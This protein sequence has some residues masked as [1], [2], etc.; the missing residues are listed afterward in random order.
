MSAITV[1]PTARTAIGDDH[2]VQSTTVVVVG[3][4]PAGLA[5]SRH[6]TA[7]G[8]DHVVLERGRIA[9]RWRSERWD[10]LRLLTPNWLARLPEW[11]YEGDDPDGFMT[12]PEIIGHLAAYAASFA[13][14]VVEQAEVLAAR[15]CAGGFEVDTP[16]CTY[17]SAALIVASGAV[18]T[19]PAWR[20]GLSPSVAQLHSSRYRNPEQIAPGGVL[21]VGASASGLQLAHELNRAGRNVVLS[22]GT[23]IRL[24]RTYRGRDTHWWLDL[25]G[26][27]DTTIAEVAD[28]TAARRGPSLQ[29]AGTPDRRSLD[30]NRL[31]ADGVRLTG[32]AVGARGWTVGFADDLAV[33]CA[34]ADRRLH[35]LLALFDHVAVAAGLT[36]EIAPPSRPEPTRIAPAVA[37]LDLDM[38]GVSTVLWATG[39]RR[40]YPWLHVPVTD[41]AG[42]I[43]HDGGISAWPGLYT[44]GLPFMRRRKSTFLDGIREDSA[45]IVAH[46]ATYLGRTRHAGAPDTS[47]CPARRRGGPA[48][49]H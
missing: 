48:M 41:R 43:R 1:P 19:M 12:M 26:T 23:H 29:L 21:V 28:L 13:A 44:M 6:L 27:L 3:G 31:R 20:D 10:S 30:L 22:V 16:T 45:D 17:R 35:R 40:H 32:R 33:T 37:A 2:G 42:E 18:P 7:R 24:P 47:D 8:I 11:R 39:F 15:P 34:Q 38:Y 14:P 25:A 36:D 46:L 5:T 49:R 9:E 4:G